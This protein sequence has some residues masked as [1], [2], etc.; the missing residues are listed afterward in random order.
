MAIAMSLSAPDSDEVENV[1]SS[2]NR[3][4]PLHGEDAIPLSQ[5]S[6]VELLPA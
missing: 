4:L 2:N 1:D 5:Q 3:S 6:D